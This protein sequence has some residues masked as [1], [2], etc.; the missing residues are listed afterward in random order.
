MTSSIFFFVL[1]LI[2]NNSD[3]PFLCSPTPPLPS[4]ATSVSSSVH[5]ST[6]NYTF[7]SSIFYN[8]L[9]IGTVWT[10]WLTCLTQWGFV[11]WRAASWT[12]SS[13]MVTLVIIR[14]LST[15]QRAECTV[16]FVTTF[17]KKGEVCDCKKRW[18]FWLQKRLTLW[19]H[20]RWTLWL[21]KRWT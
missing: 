8:T 18:T 5:F 3:F 4:F 2:I 1:P 16:S 12:V 7:K 6:N 13:H 21:Q 17:C 10:V 20:K 19:L 9:T 14:T 11:V 15:W